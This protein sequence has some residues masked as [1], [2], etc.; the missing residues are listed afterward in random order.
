MRI[1]RQRSIDKAVAHFLIDPRSHMRNSVEELIEVAEDSPATSS[2]IPSDGTPKTIAR[3]KYEVLTENPYRYTEREF[4]KV[5]H[6]DIRG[7][8]DLKIESYNIKRAAL[9]RQFGWGIHR[10]VNGTLALIPMESPRYKE[11]QGMVAVKKT[12]AY[13]TKGNR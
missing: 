9:V 8:R 10:S 2:V 12:K 6:F 1:I 5:V 11:L 13:R 3:V 7:R 4:F